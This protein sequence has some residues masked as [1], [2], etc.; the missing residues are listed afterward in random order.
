MT[1][2]DSVTKPGQPEE[3]GNSSGKNL[4][5]YKHA[6][7]YVAVLKITGKSLSQ[8]KNS[9][10]EIVKAKIKLVREMLT[11]LGYKIRGQD[12]SYFST[13]R[14]QP[15]ANVSKGGQF[16]SKVS[17]VTFRP[18]QKGYFS[19]GS[20]EPIFAF[21]KVSIEEADRFF[22]LP[23]EVQTKK[24]RLER[25]RAEAPPSD[26]DDAETIDIEGLLPEDAYNE[27][28]QEEIDNQAEE[29]LESLAA[30]EEKRVAGDPEDPPS[31]ISEDVEDRQ[32]RT[33]FLSDEIAI[34]VV[35]KMTRVLNYY[36]TI[37][38]DE[39]ITPADLKGINLYKE[40]ENLSYLEDYY[41]NFKDMNKNETNT[42]IRLVTKYGPG[43]KRGNLIAW[44]RNPETPPQN[45]RSRIDDT[46][47]SQ[48][49][50]TLSTVVQNE[51]I[52]ESL[53]ETFGEGEDR[54][55]STLEFDITSEVNDSGFYDTDLDPTGGRLLY[56]VRNA[57]IDETDQY[58]LS[59]QDINFVI[60][61]YE[62]T[63]SPG[64]AGV[65]I[66]M[67]SAETFKPIFFTKKPPQGDQ[68]LVQ[69]DSFPYYE[70]LGVEESNL[71]DG[72]ISRNA[73]PGYTEKTWSLLRNVYT[74]LFE[75][76]D[77]AN[78][79]ATPWTEFLPNAIS[80]AITVTPSELQEL[81]NKDEQ[82][83]V[84]AASRERDTNEND[85][86]KE[87]ALNNPDLDKNNQKTASQAKV[88]P[89][90]E[91]K[92]QR[93]QYQLAVA[94]TKFEHSVRD[95]IITCDAG[96]VSQIKSL[97]DIFN[98]LGRFDL[99]SMLKS[100]AKR[101]ARDIQLQQALLN[102][103]SQE[104]LLPEELQEDFASCSGDVRAALEL[105]NKIVPNAIEAF[106]DP[107][108][109][110]KASIQ[111]IDFATEN[112]LSFGLP[113]VNIP[114]IP[115]LDIYGFIR[116]L[117]VAAIEGALVE[118]LAKLLQDAIQEFLGCNGQGLL[119]KIIEKAA[120]GINLDIGQP[121]DLE[122]LLGPIKDGLSLDR[123]LPTDFIL[124]A[125]SLLEN[126]GVDGINSESIARFYD[127][128][129]ESLTGS[130]LKTMLYDR[131]RSGE[132]FRTVRS[133]AD[134]VFG[135]GTLSDDQLLSFF[136]AM[137]QQIPPA[138]IYTLPE[139]G[140]VICDEGT[141]D[142]AADQLLQNASQQGVSLPDLAD[143]FLNSL[144][145]HTKEV[146]K[147][148]DLLKPG[149]IEDA[150]AQAIQ[151]A[152]DQAELPEEILATHKQVSNTMAKGAITLIRD[153]ETIRKYLTGLNE[154][155]PVTADLGQGSSRFDLVGNNNEALRERIGSEPNVTYDFE[156]DSFNKTL[157]ENNQISLRTTAP[158]R[159][160]AVFSIQ[161]TSQNAG[162]RLLAQIVTEGP[163]DY[164]N[165]RDDNGR[166]L[167][168]SVLNINVQGQ[169]GVSA[170][171]AFST[172]GGFQKF[173]NV[174]D[175]FSRRLAEFNRGSMENRYVSENRQQIFNQMN[176]DKVLQAISNACV[177]SM[178]KG[179]RG[180]PI[181][182]LEKDKCLGAS[183]VVFSE[184]LRFQLAVADLIGSTSR[185]NY[186]VSDYEKVLVQLIVDYLRRKITAEMSEEIVSSV[187][188]IADPMKY[189]S[190]DNFTKEN[191]ATFEDNKLKLFIYKCLS[192]FDLFLTSEDAVNRTPYDPSR[193]DYF[194]DG[195]TLRDGQDRQR[196]EPNN[197]QVE[198]YSLPLEG[199]VALQIVWASEYDLPT[200][201]GLDF[202]NYKDSAQQL[203]LN[204]KTRLDQNK[205]GG[206]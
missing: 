4:V 77:I 17:E 85:S 181:A 2:F 37:L 66:L 48:L 65:R 171:T 154:E 124:R 135:E 161:V 12:V 139:T 165:I 129:S 120:E 81:C 72:E 203:Y 14:R 113:Q 145:D 130:E 116:Q 70:G 183:Q 144:C 92:L 180:G 197:G 158:N 122:G 6:G 187:I 162:T 90:N 11:R 194:P 36:A 23:Q 157:G 25:D 189:R 117:I 71:P 97:I 133:I 102:R 174:G 67:E 137:A 3:A 73:F 86:S 89:E 88:S 34:D 201:L 19:G 83:Q 40:I 87:D 178:D 153:S 61:K 45:Q 49:V 99:A 31:V 191:E 111:G 160:D 167:L 62:K 198:R 182:I 131:P 32:K 29:L 64:L 39:N 94:R 104:G 63:I 115:N 196:I 149:G 7:E 35:S 146:G 184:I 55:R 75:F 175:K 205:S 68:S 46:L 112:A 22:V 54:Y 147:I 26:P 192:Y 193:Y 118:L 91:Q 138:K 38:E 136:R 78:G 96:L 151:N 163:F 164:A 42:S 1:K 21:V 103:L 173:G 127:L 53:S 114:L 185:F 5:F 172:G 141:L 41:Q 43:T 82:S 18:P 44:D 16:Y 170:N 24:E 159:R 140:V 148:A 108:F 176:V 107:D 169:R 15:P 93:K 134:S 10:V 13:S 30:E 69:A 132:I 20:S 109:L 152:L 206:N 60:Y 186:K 33:V 51:E 155:L 57:T 101:L 47:Q 142:N 105:L 156:T 204:A 119:D 179:I 56:T 126:L 28:Q 125:V 199:I 195:Y 202:Q 59:Q 76:S 58:N 74:V 177:D 168:R 9:R 200:S 98:L 95:A 100:L 8:L 123:L 52:F 110:K 27:L 150:V 80:P 121:L 190:R 50:E 84:E 188:K 79:S 128:V 166:P 143:Q 106:Q